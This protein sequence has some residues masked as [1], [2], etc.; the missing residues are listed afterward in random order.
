MIRY[1]CLV[2]LWCRFIG[3]AQCKLTAIIL[4]ADRD[5]KVLDEA[6]ASGLTHLLDVKQFIIV[7][8][9]DK[10]KALRERYSKIGDPRFAPQHNRI[11][12]RNEDYLRVPF[13][14]NDICKVMATYIN[15][16]G[17]YSPLKRL[18][19]NC[20][21][22]SEVEDVL[23]SRTGWY[24][25]QI[26]K[27]LAGRLFHLKGDYVVVDG[28]VVWFKD[29]RFINHC[30]NHDSP[31][32]IEQGT[33][34]TNLI[35]TQDGEFT[36]SE[37]TYFY[38]TSSQRN[39]QYDRSVQKLVGVGNLASTQR[40]W[41]EWL[42]LE[43]FYPSQKRLSLEE[44]P[45]AVSHHMVISRAVMES[46]AAHTEDMS[47]YEKI[48]LA[49][50][51]L[52]L[53]QA[54][55]ALVCGFNRVCKH[56]KSGKVV[57][58]TISEYE[59]YFQYARKFF[60][61]TITLRPRLWANGPRAGLVYWPSKKTALT[62]SSIRGGSSFFDVRES[63][64]WRGVVGNPDMER[65]LSIAAL[66]N[67][68]K[69]ALVA[70]NEIAD[71]PKSNQNQN[72]ALIKSYVVK[73]DMDEENVLF[74]LQV[75]AD[76][77]SGWD[78]IAYHTWDTSS[79][80]NMEVIPTDLHM[81]CRSEGVQMGANKEKECSWKSVREEDVVLGNYAHEFEHCACLQ[82]L[83]VLEKKRANDLRKSYWLW[84]SNQ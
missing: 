47:K 59:L 3:Y 12:V 32:T 24:F 62:D 44:K 6:L 36:R 55:L 9:G 31:P 11:H 73:V 81:M 78:Y 38:T 16:A 5:E 83:K 39:V 75:E 67:M 70:Q 17:V 41:W 79:H 22:N 50:S 52:F 82:L 65:M 48:P 68:N 27:L 84:T 7:T 51:E 46:L 18:S 77:Y 37:C 74:Q 2:L 19:E 30:N 23:R 43:K 66:K 21:G 10:Y 34:R 42:G 35:E 45:S 80:R 29:V 40:T 61:H 4:S 53:K 15:Q 1:L 64:N 28:D 60:P 49:F 26:V 33:N 71:S 20:D 72:E 54:A 8:S 25:Q 57:S 56:P 14:K 76:R 63:R 13:A 69:S 58:E